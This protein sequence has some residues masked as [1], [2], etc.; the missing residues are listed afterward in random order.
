MNKNPYINGK[1]AARLDDVLACLKDL[2]RRG[3]IV[4]EI[5]IRERDPAPRI[6]IAPPPARARLK[7]GLRMQDRTGPRPVDIWATRLDG[8]QVEW[9]ETR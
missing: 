9:R 7:G 2:A 6:E 3:C 4:R 1:L 5:A 8:C